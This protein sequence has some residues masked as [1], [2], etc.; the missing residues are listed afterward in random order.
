MLYPRAIEVHRLKTVAGS[1]DAIGLTGYSGAE[2]SQ[3]SV[4][5][6][7]VLFTGIAASIQAAATGRKKDSSLAGDAV[8][9]PTWNIFTSK[10]ALAKG[11]VRDRDIIVDD[12]GYRYEVGQA[13]W[14]LL[15]Y[16]LTC[17]RLE[18]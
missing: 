5:G 2:Q 8:Y 17:I 12:E 1:N 7:S 9:A 13:Y 6:E 18:A 3:T 14:N 16:R 15:G 4:E 10:R 11:S